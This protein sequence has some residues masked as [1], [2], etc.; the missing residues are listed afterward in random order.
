MKVL[1]QNVI[2]SP[3]IRC[4]AQAVGDARAGKV[5]LGDICRLRVVLNNRKA[6]FHCKGL[7]TVKSEQPPMGPMQLDFCFVP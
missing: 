6:C 2:L 4:H 1:L 7:L 5:S 3:S